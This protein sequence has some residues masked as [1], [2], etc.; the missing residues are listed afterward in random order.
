VK[1]TIVLDRSSGAIISSTGAFSSSR[2]S[3]TTDEA[4]GTSQAQGAED[5]AAMVW[6]FVNAAG[7]MVTGLDAEVC[8][9]I[10]KETLRQYAI[11]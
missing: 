6:K 5:M 7:G 9:P 8:C 1:A 10:R 4:N 2:L 11:P 3:S